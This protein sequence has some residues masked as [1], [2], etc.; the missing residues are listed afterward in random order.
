MYALVY[1]LGALLEGLDGVLGGTVLGL[2]TGED[3]DIL[4]LAL[5]V[6]IVGGLGSY[7]GAI[8]G[9]IVIGLIDN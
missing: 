7:E 2:Y 8:V 5:A 6:V 1:T 9:S 4:L 3:S